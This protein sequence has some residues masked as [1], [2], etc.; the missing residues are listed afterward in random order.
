MDTRVPTVGPLGERRGLG[1]S[2]SSS[3]QALCDLAQSLCPE[4]GILSL[5]LLR[6]FRAPRL[7]VGGVR[8]RHSTLGRAKLG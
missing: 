5:I 3:S 7:A 2:P 4:E 6:L 8:T 1:V